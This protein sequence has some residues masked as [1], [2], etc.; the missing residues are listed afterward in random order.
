MPVNEHTRSKGTFKSAPEQECD[1]R[2]WYSLADDLQGHPID[3]VRQKYAVWMR[4]GVL[5]KFFAAL[6]IQSE[7]YGNFQAPEIDCDHAM[8]HMHPNGHHPPS[9]IQEPL[10]K[11][12]DLHTADDVRLSRRLASLILEQTIFYVYLNGGEWDE[13]TISISATRSA[14]EASH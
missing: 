13:R 5:Q 9:G 4:G 10:I 8:C 3:G 1:S 11:I 14:R 2:S 12:K 7:R 6:E